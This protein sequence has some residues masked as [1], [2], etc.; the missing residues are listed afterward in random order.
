MIMFYA[1]SSNPALEPTAVT[2]CACR[3]GFP[4]GGSHPRR[5]SGFGR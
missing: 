2:L 5:G 3:F 4:V 1:K